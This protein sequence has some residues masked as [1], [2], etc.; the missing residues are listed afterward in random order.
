MGLPSASVTSWMLGASLRL[1]ATIRPISPL[2]SS[3]S[4]IGRVDSPTALKVLSW[5]SVIV[6]IN[7]AGIKNRMAKPPQSRSNSSTSLYADAI[8]LRIVSQ[9]AAG[10]MYKYVL[11]GGGSRYRCNELAGFTFHHDAPRIDDRYPRAETLRFIEVVRAV[12][13]G[14][15]LLVELVEQRHDDLFGVHIN[16]HGGLVEKQHVGLVQDAG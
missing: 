8:S 1:L 16:A 7:T 9:L 13:D 15:S 11:Q 14:G 3:T 2:S 10:V 4:I 5:M 6:I 12:D